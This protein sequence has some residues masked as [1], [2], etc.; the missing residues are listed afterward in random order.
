MKSF[1]ST[2]QHEA[3]QMG[4]CVGWRQG[5]S[6]QEVSSLSTRSGHWRRRRP[7]PASAA[8]PSVGR[9]SGVHSEFCIFHRICS[10][11]FRSPATPFPAGEAEQ[12]HVPH[13]SWSPLSR[14]GPQLLW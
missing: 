6:K 7:S 9:D 13:G 10:I 14:L 11:S 3:R 4:G 12:P 2:V 5:S 8:V 1:V